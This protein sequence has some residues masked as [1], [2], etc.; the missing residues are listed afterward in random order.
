MDSNKR[1]AKKSLGQYWL[2][3]SLSLEAMC[4]AADVHP[5]DTVLEVGPGTGE[6]TQKLLETGA[7]VIA[8][9]I[10]ETLLLELRHRFQ[11]YSSDQLRLETGDIR[12]YDLSDIATPYKIVANIP[13]YLTSH[14]IRLVSE[15]ANPPEAAALL[16]QKE[17]AQRVVAK[18]GDMSLLSVTAQFYWQVS[19]GALV[20]A[21][22]FTPPPDVDSQVLILNRR[23]KPLFA[24]DEKRFFHLVKA[25]FSAR[26]KKLRSSLAAGLRIDK[27]A[28]E[29]LLNK[30]G[31]D[32]GERAQALSLEAWHEI[33]KAAQAAGIV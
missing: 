9:E 19:L 25:G 2:D 33:Y 27:P 17:V 32:P 30:A 13:Y 4:V 31:V 24:V 23:G 12:T 5:G 7:I 26:R 28:A 20:P 16:V 21:E 11:G 22:L 10:D 3:D 15:T 6:L 1:P 8:L 29:A 18:P 14:L